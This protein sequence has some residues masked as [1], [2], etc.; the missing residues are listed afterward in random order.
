MLFART[1][2]QQRIVL[3]GITATVSV[4]AEGNKVLVMEN[5]AMGFQDYTGR[6]VAEAALRW[7]R[8]L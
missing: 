4:F 2:P 7:F 6:V 1:R 5:I 8:N 3:P